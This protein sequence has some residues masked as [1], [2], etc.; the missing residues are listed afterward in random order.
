MQK[1]I[2]IY[3][4]QGWDSAPSLVKAVRESWERLNP[5]YSV[6]SLDFHSLVEF[7]N[8]KTFCDLEGSYLTIQE[9]S[10]FVRLELLHLHGGIWVDATAWCSEP[11]ETWLD[12]DK[13]NDFFAFSNPGPDRL[14]SNWFLATAGQSIVIKKLR[15]M[16]FDY[17]C[18]GSFKLQNSSLGKVIV[19]HF[20]DR[21]NRDISSTLKWHSWT[22]RNLL[23]VYPYF[24]FHYTFNNLVLSDTE[25]AD[26]WKN[27]PVL[28]SQ[29]AHRLQVLTKQTDGLEKALAYISMNSTPIHK[30]DWRCDFT[31]EYWKEILRSLRNSI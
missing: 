9:I 28:K 7:V 13:I 8:L 4:H 6:V 24:I 18:N 16:Y 19:N 25:C 5:S 3:W 22:S 15:A 10:N 31:S 20:T 17:F 23:Q 2:W 14:A 1:V 12:S 29:P 30:L 27:V 11:L 26:I 21:W